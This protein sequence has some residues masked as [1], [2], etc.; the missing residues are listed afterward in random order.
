VRAPQALQIRD[1]VDRI[2]KLRLEREQHDPAEM[3]AEESIEQV[4]LFAEPIDEIRFETDEYGTIKWVEGAP[5]GRL[6]A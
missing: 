6:L 2:E 1:I 4:V 3:P 5:T